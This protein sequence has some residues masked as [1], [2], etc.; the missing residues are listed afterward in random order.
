MNS[1]DKDAHA[2]RYRLTKEGEKAAESWEKAVEGQ[3]KWSPKIPAR[4]PIERGST[5]HNPTEDNR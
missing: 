5:R 1:F 2:V 3:W 4:F